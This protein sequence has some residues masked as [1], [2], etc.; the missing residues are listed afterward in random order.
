[1]TPQF[2]NFTTSAYYATIVVK[3][4]HQGMVDEMPPEPE[5][6]PLE[7]GTP[8]IERVYQ[9]FCILNHLNLAFLGKV[10]GGHLSKKLGLMKSQRWVPQKNIWVDE[11][12][13]VGT[14]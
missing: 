8:L 10:R 11:K 1:M 7:V 2:R 5:K 4:R 3:M 14:P 13:E 9:V 12:S 6:L